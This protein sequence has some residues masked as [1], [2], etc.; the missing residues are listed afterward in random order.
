MFRQFKNQICI[1]H[2]AHLHG[3]V[4]KPLYYSYF[5]SLFTLLL[6]INIFYLLLTFWCFFY[7][8]S[9]ISMLSQTFRKREKFPT[10]AKRHSTTCEVKTR[11]LSEIT[12][13]P[14]RL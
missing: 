14:A 11:L 13:R 9:I 1:C 4:V 6:S 3:Y 2:N 5:S 10:H 12:L 8:K 7:F